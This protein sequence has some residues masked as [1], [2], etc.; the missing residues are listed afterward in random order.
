MKKFK[1]LRLFFLILILT[2]CSNNKKEYIVNNTQQND[3]YGAI[4]PSELNKFGVVDIDTSMIRNNAIA[5]NRKDGSK[6][7]YVFSQ[8]IFFEQ[9]NKMYLIDD[10]LIENKHEYRE[11]GYKY[12][13]SK[14]DIKSYYNEQLSKDKGIRI[15]NK[16]FS[17]EII[18]NGSKNHNAI[19]EEKENIINIKKQMVIYKNALSNN[20]ELRVYPSFL[21]TNMEIYTG[22]NSKHDFEFLIKLNNPKDYLKK[23]PGGYIVILNEYVD[24]I[25]PLG[26]IQKPIICKKNGTIFTDNELNIDKVGDGIYKI[27]ILID[28]EVDL[29]DSIIYSAFDLYRNKQPDNAIFS[30]KKNLA[31]NHLNNCAVIGMSET[32][33][34][35]RLLIRFEILKNF[36]LEANQIENVKFYI[37]KLGKSNNILS[38][39]NVKKD[40][41]AVADNWNSEY[42]TEKTNYESVDGNNSVIFDFTDIM[43]E[44]CKD[45]TGKLEHYGV[46]VRQKD[47]TKGN[48]IML[49]NDNSLY[50]N[51][52]IILLRQSNNKQ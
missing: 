44:W 39:Y 47:E 17:F 29:S 50:I 48:M 21:G 41:C 25:N 11:E 35:G 13:I 43:K 6:V 32:Y 4:D 10:R 49:C 18:S 14:N 23:E 38:I 51:K 2:A 22:D 15:E 16:K 9:N 37:G 3:Y 46:Q 7:L 33:G 1:C 5:F 31:Y 42:D 52:C 45:K 34:I 27:K 20:S 24:E 30:N 28:E 36:N 12:V 19:C 26:V 40:W 8:D